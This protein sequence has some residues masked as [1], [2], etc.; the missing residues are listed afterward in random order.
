MW[1]DSIAPLGP[2]IGVSHAPAN[3]NTVVTVELAM[4][5]GR[6]KSGGPYT[7]LVAETPMA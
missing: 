3:S 4:T 2:P 7:L 6:Q 1:L 5:V